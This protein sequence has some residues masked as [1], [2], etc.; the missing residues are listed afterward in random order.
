[1]PKGQ[2]NRTAELG[3]TYKLELMQSHRANKV[4]AVTHLAYA[5]S[6]VKATVQE[7]KM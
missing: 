3:N 7:Y 5:M 6:N 2:P 1:M 4:G